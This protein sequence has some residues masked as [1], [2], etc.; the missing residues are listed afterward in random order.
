MKPVLYLDVDD[1]PIR[2]PGR[3]TAA[4]WE[5][6]PSGKA[7]DGAGDFIRW[8]VA[9]CEVRWLTAWCCSGAMQDGGAER[10]AGMLDVDVE[11]LR[12]IHNPMPWV[13]YKTEAVNFIEHRAGR[14][15]IWV[16]DELLREERDTL[17]A[18]GALGNFL[19]TNSSEDPTALQRALAIVQA[20]FGV[21]VAA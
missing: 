5:Q 17:R 11:I 15:W 4:W 3:E 2:Y 12:E 8:A 1:T 19:L 21:A 9:N 14:P 18:R 6:Y 7:A 10:L 16:E 13:R 20:R